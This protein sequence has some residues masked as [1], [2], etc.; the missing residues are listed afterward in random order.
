MNEQRPS[1]AEKHTPPEKTVKEEL[2]EFVDTPISAA[3]ISDILST[4]AAVRFL[5]RMADG[6]QS[7]EEQ[8]DLVEI[9]K[10]L[11]EEDHVLFGLYAL[12]QAHNQGDPQNLFMSPRNFVEGTNALLNGFVKEKYPDPKSDI[13]EL[14]E[15]GIE[16]AQE[17]LLHLMYAIHAERTY[18]PVDPS[19]YNKTN[20]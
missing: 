20:A 9:Y 3:E 14:A 8:E 4:I 17:D 11:A 5:N 10:Q 7:S 1:A 13:R 16:E 18:P 15:A 6:D 12:E 19:H 2:K